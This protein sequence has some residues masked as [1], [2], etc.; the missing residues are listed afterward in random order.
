[1]GQLDAMLNAT[2]TNAPTKCSNAQRGHY[3]HEC[4]KP[5]TWV[6]YKP[7]SYNAAETYRAGFCDHCKRY[8]HEASQ[9]K[10]WE[11]LCA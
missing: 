2:M 5:A 7:S 9:F 11:R 10:T 1:M 3:N 4:G 6:A 8:G